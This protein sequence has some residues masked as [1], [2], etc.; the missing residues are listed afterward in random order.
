[1]AGRNEFLRKFNEAFAEGNQKFI[2]EQLSD[3]IIWNFLGDRTIEGKEDVRNFI[4]EMSC[5]ETQSMEISNI[6]THG[7]TAAVDGKMTIKEE[8][9]K[10]KNFAFCDIYQFTGFKNAKIGKMTSYVI[11]LKR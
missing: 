11:P 4:E 1:M 2:L 3:E 7:K 8:S 10:V 6:I 9:G 5:I